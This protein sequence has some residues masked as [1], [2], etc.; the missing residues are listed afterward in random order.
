LELS[1]DCHFRSW[2]RSIG[3]E[4]AA[5][6]EVMTLGDL[7]QTIAGWVQEAIKEELLL[8]SNPPRDRAIDPTEHIVG[9]TVTCTYD[10]NCQ[11]VGT[12]W[13]DV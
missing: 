4:L 13:S 11:L 5:Q 1:V 3:A 7:A 10:P 9:G 2:N 6:L 8:L 12:R